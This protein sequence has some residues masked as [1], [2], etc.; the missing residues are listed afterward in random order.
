MT[1]PPAGRDDGSAADPQPL[2]CD[3][4]G[5]SAGALADGPPLTWTCSVENGVRRHFC[6][7][8]SR[9]NL[10]AIEGRLDSDWW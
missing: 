8:C 1:S 7:S 4:C 5:T 2:V 6:E 3:R 10:R 9:E